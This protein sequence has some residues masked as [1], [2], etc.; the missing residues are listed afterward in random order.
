MKNYAYVFMGGSKTFPLNSVQFTKADCDRDA[1][2]GALDAVKDVSG[3][4]LYCF[5]WDIDQDILVAKLSF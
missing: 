2:G 4:V 3:N 5:V 1:L